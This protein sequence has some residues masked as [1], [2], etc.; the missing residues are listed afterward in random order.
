MDF[1][2]PMA[3][4]DYIPV[5]LFGWATVVLQR[6]FY[7]KMN[8]GPFALYCAGTIMVVAAGISKATW[9]LLVALG[10]CDFQA[11]NSVFMPMQSLGFLLSAI[12]VLRFV[13]FRQG[14]RETLLSLPVISSN[15]PFVIVLLIGSLGVC[16][17]YSI[18]ALRRKRKG[19]CLLFVLY[20]VLLLAM[21]YLS[22]RD[23]TKASMNWIGEFVNL[24][25][26]GSLL[27]GAYGL[28][29]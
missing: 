29:K 15:M 13:Y 16:A 4:F 27:L 28:T 21:G 12:A 5:I 6:Y 18:L 10:L 14:R 11:L 3:L 20:F 19:A 23:F 24:F 7:E 9:K 1:S 2:L 8:R 25:A 17:G 26:Q 22:S